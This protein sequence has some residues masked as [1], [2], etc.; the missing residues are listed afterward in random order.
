MAYA[1][2]NLNTSPCVKGFSGGGSGPMGAL[3][4]GFSKTDKGCDSRQTAVIF[5]S[6]GNDH[7]AAL[8]LCS[9]DAAKR[10]HLTLADCEAM[11]P[12]APVAVQGPVP[13]PQGPANR[14]CLASARPCSGAGPSSGS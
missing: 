9:T 7:A 8:V 2:D 5:H 14:R 4:L 1:P 12:P 13:A 11:L 3:S 6:L 10:A